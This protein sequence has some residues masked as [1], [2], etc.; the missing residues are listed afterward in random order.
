MFKYQLER[1]QD[2]FTEIEDLHAKHPAGPEDCRP[3]KIAKRVNRGTQHE[4]IAEALDAIDREVV[5]QFTAI[6]AKS[7]VNAEGVKT[8]LEKLRPPPLPNLGAVPRGAISLTDAHI[9][10]ASLLGSAVSYLTN[11]ALGDEPCVLTGMA[12][13]GKSFL[14]SAVVRDDKVREHFR[15]GM[16]WWRVGHDAKDQLHEWLEGLALRVASASGTIPPGLTAWKT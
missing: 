7:S 15:A 12:G 5:R 9:S 16:F 4:P 13:G 8:V 1:L 6:A 11:T 10:R 2:L 3:A 14:A